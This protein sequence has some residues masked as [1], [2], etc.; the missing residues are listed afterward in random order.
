MYLLYF[1]I[2]MFYLDYNRVIF[3]FYDSGQEIMIIKNQILT[4]IT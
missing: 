4:T 1:I 3:T 2:R